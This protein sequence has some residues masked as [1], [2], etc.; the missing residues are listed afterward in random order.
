MKTEMD[1]TQLRQSWD[2]LAQR[3]PMWAIISDPNKKGR[4]WDSAAF[5]QSGQ[6][7]IDHILKHAADTNFPLVRGTALDFGCG[8]GRLTQALARHFKKVYGVDISH[9]MIA[10]ATRYNRFSRACTYIL[11]TAPD[12]RWFRS[13]TFDL[14]YSDAVLQHIPPDANRAYIAEFVRV[15]KPGGLLI[16]QVPSGL[17]PA[18]TPAQCEE[19]AGTEPSVGRSETDVNVAAQT[20][21]SSTHS[22]A[23]QNA[24]APPDDL[25][26]LIEMHAV[27]REEV[28]QV[29]EGGGATILQ[30]DEE[31]WSGPEWINFRYWVTKKIPPIE[32][33]SQSNS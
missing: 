22:V 27:P 15:L 29:L 18:A 13:D 20:E 4:K 8:L 16:F 9:N 1:L 3:D 26:K 33:P 12:L 19:A 2:I 5:F 25:E 24:A 21:D 17:R 28:L 23:E 31:N 7:G 30:V 11:N 14:V 6:V 32:S 10:E